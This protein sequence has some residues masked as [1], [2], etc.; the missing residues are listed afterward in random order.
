MKKEQEEMKKEERRRKKKEPRTIVGAAV[1][2]GADITSITCKAR[3]TSASTIMTFPSLRTTVQTHSFVA[4]RSMPM[5][6]TQA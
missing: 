3:Q 4:G 1:W 5:W 2:T 6:F